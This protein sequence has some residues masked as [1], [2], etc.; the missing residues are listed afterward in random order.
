MHDIFLSNTIVTF[1]KL[2]STFTSRKTYT[3]LMTQKIWED[4][5]A[6]I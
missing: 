2:L 1:V 4:S 3:F 5:V 6:E